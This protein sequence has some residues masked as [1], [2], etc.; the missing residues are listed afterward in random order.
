MATLV[1]D[2]ALVTGISMAGAACAGGG[3]EFVNDGQTTIDVFNGDSGSHNVTIATPLIIGGLA[4]A[5]QVVA[6]AAGAIKRI[7]PF[8]PGIYN[9]V[10]GKVQLTYSA[11]TAQTIK[12]VKCPPA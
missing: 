6:V 8:P 5:E 11:V 3:D 10:N 4:V 2:T 12:V 1:V 7:G 9:D